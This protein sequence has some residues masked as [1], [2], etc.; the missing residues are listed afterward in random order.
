MSERKPKMLVKGQSPW[1]PGE[2]AMNTG[3]WP[4]TFHGWQITYY[5]YV[6]ETEDK[7]LWLKPEIEH[8]HAFI[9]QRVKMTSS[10][11]EWNPA[12]MQYDIEELRPFCLLCGVFMAK[13]T[14]ECFNRS[15]E[16]VELA[17]KK[18]S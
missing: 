11:P 16:L 14:W 6:H 18:G 2:K 4:F 12:T 8:I 17:V 5:P 1:S 10:L 3:I 13:E 7:T 9:E 15:K